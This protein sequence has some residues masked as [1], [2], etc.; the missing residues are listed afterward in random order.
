[1]IIN[2]VGVVIRGTNSEHSTYGL[3]KDRRR[4]ASSLG[5]LGSQGT[6][7]NTYPGEEGPTKEEGTLRVKLAFAVKQ[8]MVRFSIGFG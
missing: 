7:Q 6:L 4:W 3:T 1:M 5:S 8:T 2:L